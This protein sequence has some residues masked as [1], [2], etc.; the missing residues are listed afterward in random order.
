M[1]KHAEE[2]AID[3][4]IL[5]GYHD[6]YTKFATLT[7]KGFF[8]KYK[9]VVGTTGNLGISVGVMGATLDFEVTVHMSVE[10]K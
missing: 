3:A 1:L 2:L 6:D 9:I 10:A 8:K 7:F 5:S 4:G